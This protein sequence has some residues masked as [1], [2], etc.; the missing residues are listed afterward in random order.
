MLVSGLIFGVLGWSKYNNAIA[1]DVLKQL[2]IL[3]EDFGAVSKIPDATGRDR[4]ESCL[5]LPKFCVE[6]SS[7]ENI[8]RK[9]KVLAENGN[10][11]AGALLSGLYVKGIG[12]EQDQTQAANW[13]WKT[14]ESGYPIFQ[15]MAGLINMEH[16]RCDMAADWFGKAA[17][18]GEGHA[19]GFLGILYAEG[20]GVIKDAVRA[21][22][23]LS[24][25]SL[26]G[27]DGAAGGRDLIE[28]E[29]SSGQI[30]DAERLARE[31]MEKHQK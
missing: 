22:M 27:I 21:Y 30:A 18:Q 1:E 3:D 6:G 4:F 29:M 31:W 5:E 26:D 8:F 10:L 2:E 16:E 25:A 7:A 13:F 24:L 20:K 15:T 17:N 9:L 11:Y 23:W 12:V 19:K 14:A 28:K